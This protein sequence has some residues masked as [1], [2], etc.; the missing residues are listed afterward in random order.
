MS[1][2]RRRYV[3]RGLSKEGNHEAGNHPSDPEMARLANP[4]GCD[5]CD[6]RIASIAATEGPNGS[7]P[8]RWGAVPLGPDPSAPR[9]SGPRGTFGVE[10]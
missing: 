7:A 2:P 6:A 4:E 5:A 9:A 1:R 10:G 3:T 8:T